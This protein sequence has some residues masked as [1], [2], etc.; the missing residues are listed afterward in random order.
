MG[1][2]VEHTWADAPVTSHLWEYMLR[3]DHFIIGY[4][5]NGRSKGASRFQDLPEPAHLGW[6]FEAELESRVMSCYEQARE[7]VN[8]VDMHL[9]VHDLFGKNEFK[10][11]KTSPDAFV[12][13]ALQLA[14]YNEFSD[15]VLTYESSMT[16][17]FRYGR[18]ETIRSCS[19][20]SCNWVKSMKDPNATVSEI[21]ILFQ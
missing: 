5:E 20:E 8:D 21:K 11:C 18:T 7:M 6:E 13:M 1:A 3:D 17:L 16:R 15:F 2:N 12:Q 9:Y 19:V 10:R 4:D 14:Y